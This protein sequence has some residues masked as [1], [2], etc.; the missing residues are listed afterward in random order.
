MRNLN[1]LNVKKIAK[2]NN[3]GIKER[4]GTTRLYGVLFKIYT[5][6]WPHFKI[7]GIANWLWFNIHEK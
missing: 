3:W 1:N 7:S 5:I 4:L 2:I 6:L